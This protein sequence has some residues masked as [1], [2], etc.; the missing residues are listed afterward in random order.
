LLGQFRLEH[1][2]VA[3]HLFFSLSPLSITP[4][5]R[6]M[7]C[8]LYCI[9]KRGGGVVGIK[10]RRRYNEGEGGREFKQIRIILKK[11]L[12]RERDFFVL[13]FLL[14]FPLL[15][16]VL[17]DSKVRERERESGSK[18]IQKQQQ[19]KRRKKNLKNKLSIFKKS[20]RLTKTLK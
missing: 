3:V 14:L 20:T 4:F 17:F 6:A 10:R 1:E 12:W 5:G 8:V 19:K 18:S 7:W 9:R 13:F 16:R 2:I 15:F 11:K